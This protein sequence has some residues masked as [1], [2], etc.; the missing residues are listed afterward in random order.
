MNPIYLLFSYSW[1]NLSNAYIVLL[2]KNSRN[3]F[4]IQNVSSVVIPFKEQYSEKMT[5]WHTKISSCT[6]RFVNSVHS[7]LDNCD[8][9]SCYYQYKYL[10]P[11]KLF[12]LTSQPNSFK[13]WN[14]NVNK[15]LVDF[16]KEDY[17]V[18]FCS[19]LQF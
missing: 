14:K 18:F 9:H 3:P 2:M 8:F 11:W 1:E 5:F 17:S 15:N 12:R 4:W 19:T 10:P 6:M 16:S 7:L 13:N